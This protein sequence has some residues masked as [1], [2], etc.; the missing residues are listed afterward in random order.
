MAFLSQQALWVQLLVFVLAGLIIL[1]AGTKLARLAD[2]L[3]DL[4]GMSE[5]LMGALALGAATSL[6][7]IVTSVWAAGQGHADL[8]IS[9]A[10][11]GIAVQTVFLV[12]ADMVYRRANLEHAAASLGNT[13]SATLLIGMLFLL[14]GVS[15]LPQV[16]LGPVHPATPLLIL[17]YLFGLR[18]AQNAE[19]EG[20]WHPRETG[21]TKR[22]SPD[23]APD[24]AKLLRLLPQFLICA[25]LVGGAGYLIGT[26]GYGIVERTG[27]SQ[28][29]VGAL[30]TAT[31]TSLPELVTTIAAVRRGALAL[32]VGGI[33]GG[34]AFD[35]LLVAFSDMAYWEGSIY[36]AVGPAQ[37]FLMALTGAM[38]AVL[39]AGLL[40]R[41][42]HGPGNIG[43]ESLLI[44]ALYA[45]GVGGL[46]L[47]SG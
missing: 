15:A 47:L 14:I 43:F 6:S 32:A 19:K 26:T 29:V 12:L 8:A 39:A 41:E 36:H 10:L 17:V 42:R 9:N 46:T 33:I 23:E 45:G 1:A 38:T 22:D 16:A 30:L 44:L 34:N 27:L 40:R 3:A 13:I 25:A 35:I 24:R 7:G 28:S 21:D 5:A 11:G 2:R 18:I 20:A 4:S 37:T 31:A